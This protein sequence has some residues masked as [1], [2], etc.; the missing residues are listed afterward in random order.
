MK[1]YRSE[2]EKQMQK[3]YQTLSEK[4]RRRYAAIEAIK[5]DYGGKGYICELFGCDYKTIAK[6]I[7]ELENEEILN[8]KGIRKTGGGHK[9]AT[10]KHEGL[11]DA[12]FRVIEKYTA[13]S[14]VNEKIKWTN[15]T[16]NEIAEKIEEE[17]IKIS[18]KVAKK[19][20]KNHNFRKRKALK[21]RSGRQC[22]NRDEQ[23]Q[24][25][26]WLKGT[27]HKRDNPIVS[28]DAKKKNP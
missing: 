8:Q 28:M 26:D 6:G 25:I 15:L 22:E 13:G 27:Y 5:L 23:F 16:H 9:E 20:L 17:G 11:T 7:E 18:R 1:R 2:I 3:Y 12:F 21:T 24:K 10:E 4:D 19:L 14:P